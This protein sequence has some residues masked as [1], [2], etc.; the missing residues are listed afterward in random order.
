M[1]REGSQQKMFEDQFEELLNT[2][3]NSEQQMCRDNGSPRPTRDTE[4]HCL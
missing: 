4:L 1:Q 2:S 3:D